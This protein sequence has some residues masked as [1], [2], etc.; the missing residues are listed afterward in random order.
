[1]SSVRRVAG[2]KPQAQPPEPADCGVAALHHSHPDI[3]NGPTSS[4][5]SS[6]GDDGTVTTGFAMGST[7]SFKRLRN[8]PPR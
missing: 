2:V 8:S 5:P 7:P 3:S 4:T 1:M 6:H